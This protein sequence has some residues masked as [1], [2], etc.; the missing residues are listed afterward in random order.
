MAEFVKCETPPK[1][2]I[3]KEMVAANQVPD[4][5]AHPR[6]TSLK[7]EINLLHDT[8]RNEDKNAAERAVMGAYS[9][10]VMYE[11]ESDY[12]GVEWDTV[13]SGVEAVEEAIEDENW[14][15]AEAKIVELKRLLGMNVGGRRR[16]GTKKTTRKL[17]KS[18]KTRRARRV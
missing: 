11:R 13:I 12:D 1:N 9:D 18:R 17:R 7:S 14:Q 8:V 4:F 2:L 3:I 10:A 5:P 16:R 15:S 6:L